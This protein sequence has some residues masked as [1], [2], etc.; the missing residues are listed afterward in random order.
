VACRT[1]SAVGLTSSS[2]VDPCDPRS[3]QGAQC[4]R[5]PH[6]VEQGLGHTLSTC[7]SVDCACHDR[8]SHCCKVC[9]LMDC[10]GLQIVAGVLTKWVN[11]GQGWRHR[12]FVLKDGVLRYYRVRGYLSALFLYFTLCP[13]H[14]A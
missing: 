5:Q 9:V 3:T 11:L 13:P 14:N 12:L 7:A 8:L 2:H 6:P 1:A 10:A 4:A